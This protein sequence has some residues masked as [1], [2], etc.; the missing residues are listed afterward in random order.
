[1]LA[2]VVDWTEFMPQSSMGTVRNRGLTGFDDPELLCASGILSVDSSEPSVRVGHMQVPIPSVGAW[3]C[4]L[5][6][7]ETIRRAEYQQI[8]LG[9]H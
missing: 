8:S 5:V 7:A 1:M 6:V 9:G 3:A 2:H 4:Q